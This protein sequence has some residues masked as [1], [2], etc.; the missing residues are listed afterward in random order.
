MIYLI[1]IASGAFLVWMAYNV[2]K[3]DARTGLIRN[4]WILRGIKFCAAALLCMLL[5]SAVTYLGPLIIPHI[6]TAI[7]HK[8]LR[9]VVWLC[10]RSSRCR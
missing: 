3:E 8:L 2:S 7:F 1:N 9:G 5:L 6:E 10:S 4:F